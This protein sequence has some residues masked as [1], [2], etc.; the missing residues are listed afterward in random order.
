M[1]T[2]RLLISALVIAV[3]DAGGEI[4]AVGGHHGHAA[5]GVHQAKGVLFAN[6]VAQHAGVSAGGARVARRSDS[7]RATAPP[8]PQ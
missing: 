4:E 2:K 5:Q 8:T 3:L 7:M 1:T 6:V